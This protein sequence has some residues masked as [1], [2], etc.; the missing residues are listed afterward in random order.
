MLSLAAIVDWL[1]EDPP[2]VL[3]RLV[4]IPLA[5]AVLVVGAASAW[6]AYSFE[7][8][9]APTRRELI[10][11]AQPGDVVAAHP[12][13]LGDMLQWDFDLPRESVE[14]EGLDPS[15]TWARRLPG[16]PTGR[17]WIIVPDTYA[18]PELVG[19]ARPCDGPAPSGQ[20]PL[21]LHCVEGVG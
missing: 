13:F 3:G 16:A 2:A 17:L 6:S 11:R 15:T 1:V 5:I 14:V 10:A 19:A 9:F 8:D 12:R 20:P 4:P 21:L 7:E 18:R